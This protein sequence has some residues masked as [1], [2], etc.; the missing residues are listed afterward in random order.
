MDWSAL[1]FCVAYY[2]LK[3]CFFGVHLK[4]E[5]VFNDILLS[6]QAF[7]LKTVLSEKVLDGGNFYEQLMQLSLAPLLTQSL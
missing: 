2:R 3:S 4:T 7:N 1:M 6:S 5:F